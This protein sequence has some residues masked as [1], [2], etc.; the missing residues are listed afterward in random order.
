MSAFTKDEITIHPNPVKNDLKIELDFD[1][2]AIV[3]LY[4]ISGKLMLTKTIQQQQ[5]TIS[6]K[7][8][9]SGVY[10]INIKSAQKTGTYKIVKE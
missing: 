1:E 4:N 9:S 8:I 5:N 10:F 7:D 3:S 6:L 2:E